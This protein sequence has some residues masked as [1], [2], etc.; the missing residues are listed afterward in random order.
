M[1]EDQI[2]E[3][4]SHISSIDNID[5]L[6]FSYSSLIILL[7]QFCLKLKSSEGKSF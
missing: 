5:D 4:F 6:N 7:I 1:D 3:I 2:K